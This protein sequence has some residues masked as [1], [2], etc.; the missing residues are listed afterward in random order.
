MRRLLTEKG[1]STWRKAVRG[2]GSYR[3]VE[4]RLYTL[5]DESPF[6]ADFTALFDRGS[7]RIRI[8]LDD[9]GLIARLVLR[10]GDWD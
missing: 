7:L 6:Q 3:L 9:N 8:A 4:A 5:A 1:A 10:P 2:N